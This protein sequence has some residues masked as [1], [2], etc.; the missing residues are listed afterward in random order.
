MFC[1]QVADLAFYV[2]GLVRDVDAVDAD[3]AGCR[4]Q[5][6]TDHAKRSRFAGAVRAEQTVD[7]TGLDF[8]ADVIDRRL[9]RAVRIGENFG[10]VCDFDHSGRPCGVERAGSV[11]YVA[12]ASNAGVSH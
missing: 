10:Q 7:F 9:L 3:F 12:R 8:E 2:L 5:Q 11:P 6:P 1:C 4:S